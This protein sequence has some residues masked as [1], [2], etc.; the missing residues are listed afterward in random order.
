M[1][2]N[3]QSLLLA[4]QDSEKLQSHQRVLIERVSSQNSVRQAGMCQICQRPA[5]ELYNMNCTGEQ[6]TGCRSCLL[7]HHKNTG[8]CHFCNKQVDISHFTY[9]RGMEGNFQG[10][11]NMGNYHRPH[12]MNEHG[13]GNRFYNNQQQSNVPQMPIIPERKLIFDPAINKVYTKQELNEKFLNQAR[14]F[15][16][17]CTNMDNLELSIQHREWATT[18]SNQVRNI[19][20]L[21][22]K[23]TFFFFPIYYLQGKLDEAFKSDKCVILLFSVNKSSQFQ[24][25]ARMASGVTNRQS[26][27]W[28]TDGNLSSRILSFHHCFVAPI[29]LGGL[30]SIE[31]LRCGG[32]DFRKTDHMFNSN[33]DPIKKSR[34]SQVT[35]CLVWLP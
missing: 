13:Y 26:N 28:K 14:F 1:E 2:L 35:I 24:G 30:F 10:H 5:Q 29:K 23:L 27:Y 17:K 7:E 25:F 34:D 20:T 11:N 4:L 18:R 33:G 21:T 32:V 12:Q 9:T 6:R 22:I 3:F 15:M 16:I 8:L 19:F 31:W